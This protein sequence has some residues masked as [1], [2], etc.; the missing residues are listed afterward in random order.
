V[1]VLTRTGGRIWKAILKKRVD[2]FSEPYQPHFLP[3]NWGAHAVK[4]AQNSVPSPLSF[5]KKASTHKLK[6]E[7]LESVKLRVPLKEKC[8]YITVTSGPF[9]SKVLY[10]LQLLLWALW[11][12]SEPV[13]TLHLIL[14]ASE[15]VGP[16]HCSCYCGPFESR[17]LIQC[18]QQNKKGGPR[19]V[20]RLP[21]LKPVVPEVGVATQTTVAKGQKM[22]R[23]EAI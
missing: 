7:A 14:W 1:H 8:L 19:Q 9:E 20:T 13:Y 11:K 15:S 21:S 22:V 5:P 17:V 6:Y 3:P 23:A 18:A 2:F 12:R 10:T 4:R 16:T